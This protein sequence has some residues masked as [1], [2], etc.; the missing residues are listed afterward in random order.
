[1]IKSLIA[2]LIILI[3]LIPEAQEIDLL[4]LNS[5]YDKALQIIDSELTKDEAQPMLYLKKGI[6][7][8]KSFDFAGA[9]KCLER[10]HQ[11]DSLNAKILNELGELNS[12]LGDQRQALYYFK[13]LF[14]TD[15]TNYVNTLKLVRA[16]SNLRMYKEPFEIL[17]SVY[18]RDST[19][20]LINKNLALCAGRTGHNDFSISLYQKV[21]DLNPS[22]LANFTNLASVYQS[23]DQ[24]VEAIDILNKGLEYFPDEP[25]LL[26]KLGQFHFHLKEYKLAIDP[27]EKYLAKSD[28]VPEVMTNLGICYYL[29]NR[30]REGLELFEKN[31]K[32]NPDDAI[33]AYY[34]GLCYE[35]LKNLKKSIEYLKLA[36]EIAIPYYLTD[37]YHHLGNVYNLSMDYKKAV[38]ALKKA[39]ELDSS[40]CSILF[41]IATNYD[42]IE[43]SKSLSL[44]YYDAFL[45]AVRK[46]DPDYRKLITYAVARIKEIK[47]ELIAKKN[48]L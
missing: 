11:L 12:N 4:I 19:N 16:Y 29:E 32:M 33:S 1:M 38:P 34:I 47:K 35:K 24:Y 9:V 37:I 36:S 42:E 2:V 30:P 48:T 7:L 45:K 6:I 44:K 25:F 20:L 41:E 31:L 28:S 10:A 40:K 18:K 3:P 22:D 5:E 21:I 27:F 13:A 15:T 14:R 8:Q 46:D 26:I 39:Y 43:N 17:M 23:K